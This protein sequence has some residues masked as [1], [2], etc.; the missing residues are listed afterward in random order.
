MLL[1]TLYWKG[2]N[3]FW[4]TLI[5]FFLEVWDCFVTSLALYMA[6]EP[7]ILAGCKWLISW[8]R[9]NPWPQDI[10]AINQGYNTD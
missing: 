3:S 7:E 9:C 2:G 1:F 4:V 8:K 5:H 6:K 10:N